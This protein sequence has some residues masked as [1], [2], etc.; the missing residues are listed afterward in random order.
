MISGTPN[1]I[2]GA[3][4]AAMDEVDVQDTRA[5]DDSGI[6]SA[7]DSY[8]G[9]EDNVGIAERFQESFPAM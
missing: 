5:V 1:E 9:F 2:I 8:S 7:A 3:Y 4:I 6:L